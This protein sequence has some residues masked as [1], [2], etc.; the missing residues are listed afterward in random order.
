[1]G[2]AHCVHLLWAVVSLRAQFDPPVSHQLDALAARAWPAD[3]V[4]EV[5]GWLLRRTEGVSRRRSN[6]LLAPSD[7]AHA[8]RTV[9][10][11][12]ETAA[13]LDFPTTIQVAPAE[14]HARLDAVLEDRGMHASGPSLVLAGPLGGAGWRLDADARV[15]LSPLT[16]KWVA[17]CAA[18]SELD[19]T[20][21]TAELVLSQLGDRARFATAVDGEGEPIAVG[22]GVVEEGWLGLFSLG[23]TQQARRRGAASAIVTALERWASIRGAR[24]TYLQVERD[25]TAAVSFYARRGFHIAHSYHYRSA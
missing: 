2:V 8:A 18:V 25:N 16:G 3:E 14:V 5:E 22:I 15:A 7:P 17:A 12:L 24:G 4:H 1:M 19:G 23:T 21:E 20:R 9:D 6:S 10:L 11:A 13:E